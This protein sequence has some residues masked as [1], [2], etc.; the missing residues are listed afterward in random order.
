MSS[1]SEK[2]ACEAGPEALERHWCV[3]EI[4][5]VWNLSTDAVRKL[6]CDE[7]GVLSLSNRG[8]GRKRRYTTL[9]IPQSV[10]ERVHH[11]LTVG[12]HKCT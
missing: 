12:Y 8:R 3:T 4:A 1:P 6:F 9:R 7:P 2:V 10:L 11:R 5:D